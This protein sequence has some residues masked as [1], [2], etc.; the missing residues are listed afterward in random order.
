MSNSTCPSTHK[1]VDPV[2]FYTSG[3][4]NFKAHDVGWII[5][6]FFTLIASVT[7]FWLIWKHLTYY[8]CPQQQ[9][10]IVRMLFMVPIYAIVSLLSYIFYHQAIYYQT[11]RDCY[12]AVV[13]TSFFYLLLQYVGDTPA[14]QHEVFRMVKLKKWFWPLGFWKYRPDGLHFL[15]IMKISILQYA[16]VRP[17][18]TLVAVGLQYF[19][20]YCLESWEPWFGHIYITI[21]IS[22][23]VSVA[24][25][26]IIQFYL[27]I[28]EELKPYSPV[29]KFLAVKSVV[30]L[31]FW[32]DSFLS[33]LVYFG[34]IKQSQYMTAADIQVGINALLET[35]EMCI[36][37][38]LHIKA[39]TYVVYR[40][41]DRKRTTR[42]FKALL[43]VFDYRDWYYQM[44]QSSRY[45]A[46][47]SK[48]RDYSIV[49]DIRREKYS[50]LEKA[51]GRDRWS[52]LQSEWSAG[53][54][55]VPTF[56]KPG[57]EQ[58]EDDTSTNLDSDTEKTASTRVGEG[59]K[60]R[61]RN[62][63]SMRA[64]DE[65]EKRMPRGNLAMRPDYD[66]ENDDEDGPIDELS[67]H[68]SLLQ[69]NKMSRL[70][71]TL[72]RVDVA[73]IRAPSSRMERHPELSQYH[74]TALEEDFEEKDDGQSRSV[75]VPDDIFIP[76]KGGRARKEASLGLG[77]FWRQFRERISGS[78]AEPIEQHE[79]DEVA[80]IDVF[81]PPTSSH[82]SKSDASQ[83]AIRS[84]DS[85]L[86]QII[87][88]HGQ[89]I[90]VP[91]DATSAKI[92]Q[93][94]IGRTDA[95]ANAIQRQ[96][97]DRA[98]ITSMPVNQE[99]RS[100]AD[101]YIPK[102]QSPDPP[103]QNVPLRAPVPRKSV[104]DIESV[105]PSISMWSSSAQDHKRSKSITKSSEPVKLTE[106]AL[107]AAGLAPTSTAGQSNLGFEK[108]VVSLSTAELQRQLLAKE[109]KRSSLTAKGP[110][111]KRIAVVLPGA[112]S[113]EGLPAVEPVKVQGQSS[114]SDVPAS[115]RP[116]SQPPT[117]AVN[118]ESRIRFS[119]IKQPMPDPKDDPEA[120]IP[121][122]SGWVVAGGKSL[123]QIRE[124]EEEAKRKREEEERR[125]KEK[126][127]R[128]AF[129]HQQRQRQ[130][131]PQAAGRPRAYSRDSN[132][133]QRQSDNEPSSSSRTR[134]ISAPAVPEATDN[135]KRFSFSK[136]SKKEK[137]SVPPPLPAPSQLSGMDV[138]NV[139]FA[140]A[141]VSMSQRQS[142]SQSHIR[143]QPS[144][145]RHQSQPSQTLN[146]IQVGS[147][148]SRREVFNAMAP[149]PA[150]MPQYYPH[151]VRQA[152][153]SNIVRPP[154]MQPIRQQSNSINRA[155]PAW[156]APPPSNAVGSRSMSWQQ[157]SIVYAPQPQPTQPQ[158]SFSG[159][160]TSYDPYTGE[161]RSSANQGYS[162][163]LPHPR[164][165]LPQDSQ[166]L[167][168]NHNEKSIR[169]ETREGFQFD[170]ID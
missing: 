146:Q 74:S 152:P 118:R 77:A 138:H 133:P 150:P 75:D 47:R 106:N 66:P 52:H 84:Q 17:V 170:Y 155:P 89:E 129:E 37:A 81:L 69:S 28:Q 5:C 23:S 151:A 40:P 165:S 134:R 154:M 32:Q 103:V 53:K 18:C 131:H 11:I 25:Y 60:P 48:G 95:I 50:H 124:M 113:P 97:S 3:N 162:M 86:T 29:L 33:I 4:L 158:R 38:F 36:F 116:A 117:P 14:E 26:C 68:Q 101:A 64:E 79:E 99:P 15:W 87:R 163:R 159:T 83:S 22:I 126:Q 147:I 58:G 1:P 100:I 13:I 7:S 149:A 98:Y 148:V 43:D 169:G 70:L 135:S 161:P 42:K 122:V 164:H 123:K 27:P 78:Q 57:C 80:E 10:H 160:Q 115:L 63:S 35:F 156:P 110:K 56:W 102:V 49:E 24:M 145:Q 136:S 140:G 67:D 41:K 105:A 119:E 90:P 30:F 168:Y 142:N 82:E 76:R 137:A 121:Q 73:S 12:E 19:G 54:Q 51:L 153:P 45:M 44:R 62:T 21:A 111:G 92:G 139:L 157:Q 34:A 141:E 88:N 93:T 120:E 128:L 143:P 65:T 127:R 94:T 55:N 96:K 144:R 2:P 46:A 104:G 16:I 61:S 72:P 112:L 8:T 9:R 71:P 39:F 132:M 166:R 109:Q 125:Q 6:G 108:S 167:S 91:L 20:L 114:V 59:M 130:Q 107:K 85:P 31:T